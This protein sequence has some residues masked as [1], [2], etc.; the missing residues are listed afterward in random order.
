[1]KMRYYPETDTMFIEFSDLATDETIGVS[2][3]LYVE[4]DK[5][6]DDIAITIEGA[7]KYKDLNK[8]YYEECTGD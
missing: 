5:Q 6:R 8:L 7:S 3:N 2:D 1:M 4:L